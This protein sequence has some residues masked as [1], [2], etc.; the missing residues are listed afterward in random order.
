MQKAN[1][2]LLVQLSQQLVTICS[3]TAA[4]CLVSTLAD[5]QIAPSRGLAKVE[6]VHLTRDGQPWIPHGFHQIAFAVAPGALS[7]A[8]P[9]FGVASQNYTPQEYVLMREHGADSVLS[10]RNVFLWCVVL[11]SDTE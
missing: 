5:A 6:G 10:H 9:L 1:T 4:F 8:P 7:G 3:L 11:R 2:R